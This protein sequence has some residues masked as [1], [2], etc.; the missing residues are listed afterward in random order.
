MRSNALFG[1]VI[2]WVQLAAWASS[3]VAQTS[4]AIVSPAATPVA[5]PV[6][7]TN[8]A[9]GRSSVATHFAPSNEPLTPKCY[10]SMFRVDGLTVL[11]QALAIQSRTTQPGLTADE[12]ALFQALR[13]GHAGSFSFEEAA[14]IASGVH[15]PAKRQNY[16]SQI[17]AIAESAR[18]AVGNQATIDGKAR[19]IMKVL[20]AGP[21][22]AD[23]VN[24]QGSLAKLLDTG[25]FDCVS[26][27]VM[28]TVVAHRL[29]VE[30]GAVLQPGHVCCRV[31]GY[32]VETTDKNPDN[33]VYSVDHRI[34]K[35]HSSMERHNSEFGDFPADRPYHE[36]GDFGLLM[37]IYQNTA[38]NERA[39]KKYDQATI[40][41]LKEVALDPA[42]PATGI[43]AEQ[44]FKIWFNISIGN[45]DLAT[46]R[47]IEQLYRQIARDPSMADK[48][49]TALASSTLQ[50]VP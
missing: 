26:A 17:E 43:D 19:E 34:E 46:A 12:N 37:S 5:P 16:H 29:V 49:A 14:L 3:A 9:S 45:H 6:G 41:T 22:K 13:S 10:Q 42:M 18:V 27:S 11:Y 40:D 36:A 33:Y 20:I 44:N 31:P 21:M 30:V 23:F 7:T 28:F 50:F 24:N 2:A 47:A 8:P 38:A 48:M 39:E 25:H 1:R 35:I 15:D 32:D 4:Y